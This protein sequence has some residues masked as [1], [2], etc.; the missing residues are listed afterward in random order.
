M[1]KADALTCAERAEVDRRIKADRVKR[2]PVGATSFVCPVWNGHKLVL[3]EGTDYY[4]KKMAALNNRTKRRAPV[5]VLPAHIVERREKVAALHA[6]GFDTARIAATL[7]V[8][9]QSSI[10]NDLRRLGLMPNPYK[11]AD[12]VDWP[13]RN[14]RIAELAA[15]G[16]TYPEIAAAIGLGVEATSKAAR[17]AGIKVRHAALGR[18]LPAPTLPSNDGFRAIGHIAG[19]LLRK[20]ELER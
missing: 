19:D 9:S 13:A 10:E 15:E 12:A 20:A 4:R 14:A 16:K 11:R 5:T 6:E 1:K 8:F 2:L 7:K 3:P 18:R 17:A